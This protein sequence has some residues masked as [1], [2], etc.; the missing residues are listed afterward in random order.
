M[1]VAAAQADTAASEARAREVGTATRHALAGPAAPGRAAA[2]AP[3]AVNNP[4]KVPAG[5]GSAAP[6]PVVGRAGGGR[7][8]SA[9]SAG[10]VGRC[11][12]NRC[13][14]I[15]GLA[16]RRWAEAPDASAAETAAAKP[17]AAADDADCPADRWGWAVHLPAAAPETV[18]A[19]PEDPHTKTPG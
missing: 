16:A 13:F 10:V 14:P 9:A 3:V 5:V 18:G 15:A 2:E 7:N 12:A 1:E 11:G 19:C 8:R 4:V 17:V 6:A